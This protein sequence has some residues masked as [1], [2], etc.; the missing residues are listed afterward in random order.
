LEKSSRPGNG[1]RGFSI[2]EVLIASTIMIAGTAALAQ[3]FFASTQTN[4]AAKNTSLSAMLAQQKM[5][6][7]RALTWGFDTLGLPSTDTT[8]DTAAVPE[9]P[10]GGTGLAPSPPGTLNTNT[11][12]YVDYLDKFGSSLGGASTVPPADTLYVRRWSVEPLPTNPNNTLVLQVYV[13]PLTSRSTNDT[14]LTAGQRGPQEARMMSV[15][16]RKAS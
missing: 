8:T 9:N 12:G 14:S 6:Q 15:K 16:T 7:L 2:L 4:Q 13:R 1:E 3:M 11:L 5:E 10:A